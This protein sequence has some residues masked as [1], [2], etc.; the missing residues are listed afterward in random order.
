MSPP[1]NVYVTLTFEPSPFDI[2]I[3][4]TPD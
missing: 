2:L 1:L 4:S 3:S